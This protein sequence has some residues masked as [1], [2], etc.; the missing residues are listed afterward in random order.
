MISRTRNFRN[1]VLLFRDVISPRPIQL[2][3]DT[4]IQAALGGDRLEMV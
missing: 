2:Y 1:V 4:V 3:E